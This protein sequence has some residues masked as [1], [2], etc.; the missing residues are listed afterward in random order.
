MMLGDAPALVSPRSPSLL[1]SLS[2]CL[3]AAMGK[4]AAAKAA[5]SSG[6]PTKKDDDPNFNAGH[7]ALL[8]KAIKTITCHFATLET[9]MPPAQGEKFAGSSITCS[10]VP[11]LSNNSLGNVHTRYNN[12]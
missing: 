4:K 7:L 9:D 8:Q 3:V 2:Y 6:H 11:C 12:T 1:R 5:P 10:H